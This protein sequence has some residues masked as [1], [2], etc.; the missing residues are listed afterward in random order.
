MEI[1]WKSKLNLFSPFKVTLFLVVLE[2][3]LLNFR[4]VVKIYTSGRNLLKSFLLHLLIC[5]WICTRE[6][7]FQI[8]NP[9]IKFQVS[10]M[11]FVSC[12]KSSQR[13]GSTFPLEIFSLCYLLKSPTHSMIYAPLPFLFWPCFCRVIDGPP[14]IHW[15]SDVHL[16]KNNVPESWHLEIIFPRDIPFFIQ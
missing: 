12:F 6:G 10:A 7:P 16:L 3:N 9:V 4:L 11:I 2:P 1:S 8:Q 14:K 15:D 13:K 5:K